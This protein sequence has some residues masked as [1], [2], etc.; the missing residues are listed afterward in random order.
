MTTF[1]EMVVPEG[2]RYSRQAASST[3]QD[4]EVQFLGEVIASSESEPEDYTEILE[5][6]QK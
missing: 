6:R 3:K 5:K 1:P 4:S 2:Y